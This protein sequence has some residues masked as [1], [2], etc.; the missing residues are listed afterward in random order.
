MPYATKSDIEKI[1]GAEFLTDILP[2]DVDATEAV[3]DAL[4]LASAEIDTHL[5]ARY[6]LPLVG[7][8]AALVMPAVNIAV[9]VLANRHVALTKTIED[10]YKDATE[11]LKRMADGKAGLGPDEPRV[12]TGEDGTGQGAAFFADPRLF[13]R[14]R[15]GM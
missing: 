14:R 9:Y 6:Q 1:W 10:R 5:S 13:G 15:G 8:P 12:D 4:E 3:G 2:E 11:L 7:S